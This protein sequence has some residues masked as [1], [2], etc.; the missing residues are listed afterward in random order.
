MKGRL[1]KIIFIAILGLILVVV[2]VVRMLTTIRSRPLPELLL[3]SPGPIPSPTTTPSSLFRFL[4]LPIFRQSKPKTAVVSVNPSPNGTEVQPGETISITFNRPVASGD[5]TL[6]VG[7]PLSLE[8]FPGTSETHVFSHS[9]LFELGTT[10]TVTA[11]LKE[12]G[13]FIWSFSTIASPQ[14]GGYY[15]PDFQ[16]REQSYL[17]EHK[18]LQLFPVRRL[19]FAVEY[20]N[21]QRVIVHLI[22]PDFTAA[23]K[24]AQNWLE[25]NGVDVMNVKVDFVNK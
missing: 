5:L 25:E 14:S 9:Q 15:P 16:E 20:I 22:G 10:Y 1:N 11:T 7:L 2:M 19:R 18:L 21:E 17:E 12:E 6:V 24:D 8:S 4:P 13:T 23:K 3:A